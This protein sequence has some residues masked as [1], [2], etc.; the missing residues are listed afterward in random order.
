MVYSVRLFN[1]IIIFCIVLWGSTRADSAVLFPP[2]TESY[3]E[4]KLVKPLE[5]LVERD[6]C[7]FEANQAFVCPLRKR[8]TPLVDL[9]GGILYPGTVINTGAV[10]IR[11]GW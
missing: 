11:L 4:N 1:V 5:F 10:G 9:Y 8:G 7:H 2:T 3:G 6:L